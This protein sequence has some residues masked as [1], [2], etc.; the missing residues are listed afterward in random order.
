M[1]G[2]QTCALPICKEEAASYINPEKEVHTAEEAIEGAKDILAEYISDQADYRIYIRY[3]FTENV[4]RK[5]GR[6]LPRYV[7]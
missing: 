6:F 5:Y 1:T 3:P 4:M 2:V 7:Y